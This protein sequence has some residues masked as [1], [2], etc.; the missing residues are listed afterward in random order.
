MCEYMFGQYTQFH[1]L[2]STSMD[3]SNFKFL[4]S[5]LEAPVTLTLLA[6]NFNV[7]N[8][9]FY[10]CSRLPK[11]KCKDMT[12]EGRMLRVGNSLTCIP[13]TVFLVEHLS[14]KSPESRIISPP[15]SGRFTEWWHDLLLPR[16]V[17][18]WFKTPALSIDKTRRCFGSWICINTYSIYCCAIMGSL[19]QC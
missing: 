7:T 5:Y 14:R 3:I 1:K 18:S 6:F 17:S 19:Y 9:L 8:F 16:A 13:G 2:K 4:T 11:G 10:C 12:E 15:P